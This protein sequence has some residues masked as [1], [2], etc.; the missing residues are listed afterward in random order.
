MGQFT[1]YLQ[2]FIT[3]ES[4]EVQRLAEGSVWNSL[5]PAMPSQMTTHQAS[6]HVEDHVCIC[7]SVDKATA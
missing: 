6:I 5:G 1:P 2:E 3:R 7:F 4:R